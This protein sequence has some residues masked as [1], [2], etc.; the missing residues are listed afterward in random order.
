MRLLLKYLFGFLTKLV[1]KKYKP[2]IIGITGSFGKSSTK[3]AIFTI[4]N[5]YL[6]TRA[7]YLN[8]N[9]EI[10][11][12][13]TIID[14]F[15]ARRNI[16]SWFKN[17]VKALKLLLFFDFNYP[18]I[19][20][21]EMAA[22]QPKDLKYLT[23]MFPPK[24]GVI[25]A[26]GEMPV[27]L[28]HYQN[29]DELISEKAQIIQRLK[30]D[31]KAILNADCPLVWQL[32]DQTK[33]EVIGFGFNEISQVKISD[34]KLIQLEEPDQCGIYFRLEAEGSFVPIKLDGLI[35]KSNAYALAAGAACGLSMGLNLI[36]INEA[37]NHYQPPPQRLQLKKGKDNI[38]IID[39]SYNAS[40]DTIQMA[41][42]TLNE[43]QNKRKIAVLGDMLELGE[44]SE[45]AHQ[46]LGE[47]INEYGEVF[48]AIGENMRL[49]YEAAKKKMPE[50]KICHFSN[51]E[52]AKIFIA[53]FVKEGDL[54][55][56][57]GSR[58]MKMEEIVK[59]LS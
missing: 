49:A 59:A 19:L 4:L 54:V 45:K 6:K 43:F 7:N 36:E 2:T 22:D 39:D 14:G 13:L 25:T 26:I 48:F 8:L 40:P 50:D 15:D 52:E 46:Q 12:P 44:N 23:K 58:K 42:E 1:I 37:I 21:L 9:T 30:K 17:L 33:A 47:K 24:I 5:P 28:S 56:I 32:K 51:S 29:L 41:L 3:E 31:G 18:Q 55:L 11:V 35:G 10:G 16:F 34:Y 20:V 57:K 53:N 38:W 27:H